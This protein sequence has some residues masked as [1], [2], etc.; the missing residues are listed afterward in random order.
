MHLIP[1]TIVSLGW[2][3]SNFSNTSSKK[4]DLG[5]QTDASRFL[6]GIFCELGLL[7]SF[8]GSVWDDLTVVGK[9]IY[10]RKFDPQK[11]PTEKLTHV[12]YA[13]ANV[14]VELGEV[15]LLD[16]YAD[17]EKHY[18]MDSWNETGTNV[19]GCIKQL[20]LFK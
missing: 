1:R 3:A 2:L 9:A 20:F 12:L 5:F 16:T 13:F 10:A 19:Y 6:S 4:T 8:P 11:L 7:I 18:L 15:Y 14:W 17:T